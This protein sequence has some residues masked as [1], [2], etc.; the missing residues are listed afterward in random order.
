MGPPGPPPDFLPTH[1]V[2]SVAPLPFSWA[3]VGF[4]QDEG[5]NFMNQY[6]APLAPLLGT[7]PRRLVKLGGI[8]YGP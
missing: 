6:L 2:L 1:V 4:I 7:A 5:T 8:L 3:P